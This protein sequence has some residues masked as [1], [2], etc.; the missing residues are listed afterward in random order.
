MC[1]KMADN[2]MSNDSNNKNSNETKTS[3]DKMLTLLQN[4]GRMDV[5]TLSLSLDTPASVIDDWAK[6]LESANI[7]KIS[8]ELGKMYVEPTKN[9]INTQNLDSSISNKKS[10]IQQKINIENLLLSKLTNSMNS[11]STDVSSAQKQFSKEYPN[12]KKAMKEIQKIN[13]NINKYN[14]KIKNLNTSVN[15]AYE[16]THKNYKNLKTDIDKLSSGSMETDLKSLNIKLS[17]TLTDIKNKRGDLQKIKSDNAAAISSIKKELYEQHKDA[18]LSIRSLSKELNSAILKTRSEINKNVKELNKDKITLNNAIK[19]YNELTKV[20]KVTSGKV[21]TSKIDA[22]YN[23]NKTKI[24]EYSKQ[25]DNK[26]Q[27]IV[28]SMDSINKKFGNLGKINANILEVLKALTEA[29]IQVKS[30]KKDISDLKSESNILNRKNISKEDLLKYANILENQSNKLENKINSV[31]D[32]VKS[33]EDNL[34]SS[35][36]YEDDQ[37]NTNETINL[38]N[39]IPNNQQ[40]NNTDTNINTEGDANSTEVSQPQISDTQENNNTNVDKPD[41][42]ADTNANSTEVSQPQIS[43]TQENNNINTNENKEDQNMNESKVMNR[44]EFK[45]LMDKLSKSKLGDKNN[46][47]S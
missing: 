15:D 47:N 14:S 37:E 39:Q 19:G 44:H 41:I 31:S 17:K 22:L 46:G 12:A 36:T 40:D 1:L 42:T 24:D 35:L 43:D 30:I 6:I 45:K 28:N 5:N 16:K 23:E 27:Q 21:D 20:Y 38:E 32:M 25:F 2:I 34:S 9:E 7:V 18:L 10:T 3:I 33:S 26:Y 4:K 11:I 8:Y 13:N 29:E